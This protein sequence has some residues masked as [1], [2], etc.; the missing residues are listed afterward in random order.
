MRNMSEYYIPAHVHCAFDHDSVTFLDLRYDRYSMLR[1]ET[2]HAFMKLYFRDGQ[3]GPR[4][5]YSDGE[6]GSQ[7][8]ELH[9]AVLAELL[10][11]NL[12]TTD[13]LN[14]S[15][16]STQNA[17][18]PRQHI[19]DQE[20]T[21]SAGISMRDAWRMTTACL[22][23]YLR[24]RY[25]RLEATVRTVEARKKLMAKCEPVSLPEARRLILIYNRMRPLFPKSY[26]CLFNSLSLL[27]FLAYYGFYPSWV[28]AVRLD[29]WAAH[30]WVQ[31]ETTIL[32]EDAE[33]ARRYTPI[34]VV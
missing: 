9:R 17:P 28:F 30:C 10:S 14:A 34:M 31:H 13:K 1:G 11:N 6:V 27:E 32:N 22:A 5:I 33:E 21:L 8:G 7:C 29:P 15:L 12:V 3:S 20:S 18:V 16:S 23:S 19:F 26:L 4:P 24:L 25:Q 2:A